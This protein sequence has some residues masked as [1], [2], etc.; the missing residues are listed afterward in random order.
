[1]TQSE[2][3]CI[4][5]RG[6]TSR[7]LYFNRADLPSDQDELAELLITALGAGHPLNIDGMGGGN[8]VTTKVAM[9]SRSLDDR[10]DIDFFFAQVSVDEKLVDFAPTCGNILAGV[11]PAAVEMGL[12]DATDDQT[13]IRIFGT[14]TSARVEAIIETPGNENGRKVNYAGDTTIAGVPGSAA[15]ITLNFTDVVGAKT[16]KLF[17]TGNA[18]DFIDGYNVTCIDVATPMVIGLA[19]DFGISGYE[20]SDELDQNSV[21]FEKVESVRIKAGA[22]M[23]MGD[24]SQ[25]VVP[26]FGLLADPQNDGTIAARYFM[27][28]KTHPSYPVTG[29][30]CT[31]ACLLAPETIAQTLAQKQTPQEGNIKIEHPSGI[32]DAM[33]NYSIDNNTFTLHSAG[34]IR[35]ARKLFSGHIFIPQTQ[36]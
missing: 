25:S 8:P 2:I 11:G 16:G 22:L 26:R 12:I 32:I 3:P 20:T 5:M 4:V 6:G 10:A 15:P 9:L 35:T 1:M 13:S 33:C 27:P 14:N 24:V 28:W 36:A 34:S 31:A 18:K 7:G 29:S 23:G 30:I 17:P 19:S 21:L